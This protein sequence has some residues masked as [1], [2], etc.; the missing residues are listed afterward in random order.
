MNKKSLKHEST[1]PKKVVKKTAVKKVAAKRTV[2][3]KTAANK[4]GEAVKKAA[5][6]AS[7]RKKAV[8]AAPAK[9]TTTTTTVIAKIDVGYGNRLFIRGN[10]PDLNW[11]RGLE[12]ENI[13]HNEW[14]ITA[15]EIQEDIEVKFLINDRVWSLGDNLVLQAGEKLVFEPNFS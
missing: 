6:A 2:S 12:M 7:T 15:N 3:R 8:A 11:D 4:P 9:T 13:T 5:P 14:S 1:T 10:G